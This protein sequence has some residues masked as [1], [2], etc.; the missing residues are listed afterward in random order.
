MEN[1]ED[2]YTKARENCPHCTGY[3]FEEKTCEAQKT[4]HGPYCTRKVN[5][6]GQHVAC[7]FSK[8]NIEAWD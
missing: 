4:K 2:S 1:K 5:H 7:G 3:Y 6:D 8:H